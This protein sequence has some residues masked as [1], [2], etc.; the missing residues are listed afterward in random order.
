VFV[1]RLNVLKS[2]ISEKKN[3]AARLLIYITFFFLAQ[4][5]KTKKLKD[6][7]LIVANAI[8]SILPLVVFV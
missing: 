3:I 7:D 6:N 8:L 2:I 4:K 5:E 1:K